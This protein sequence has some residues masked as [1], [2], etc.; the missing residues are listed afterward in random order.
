MD[1]K[2]KL[3]TC[4]FCK[5]TLVRNDIGKLICPDENCIKEGKK[6]L[7]EKRNN[8]KRFQKKN[9]ISKEI[10]VFKKRKNNVCQK[11]GGKIRKNYP[12]GIMSKV[13]VVGHIGDC[14]NRK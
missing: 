11:C 4:N 1:T 6:K 2:K 7:E 8:L 13:R 10:S 14:V 3:K 5:K 12:F 9:E